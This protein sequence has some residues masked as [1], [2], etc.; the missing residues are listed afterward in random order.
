MTIITEIRLQCSSPYFSISS[1]SLYPIQPG[2]TVIID[3]GAAVSVAQSEISHYHNNMLPSTSCVATA[4]SS[5]LVWARRFG[6]LYVSY[7]E[8][9][10]ISDSV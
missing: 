10:N 1:L 6:H 3:S 5:L 4:Q 7:S 9:Y 8:D 2:S